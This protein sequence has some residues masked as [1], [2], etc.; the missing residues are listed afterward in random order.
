LQS[1]K[2]QDTISIDGSGS[3]NSDRISLSES[4]VFHAAHDEETDEF[5]DSGGVIL[6]SSTE[7]PKLSRLSMLKDKALSTNS[8]FHLFESNLAQVLNRLEMNL[9]KYV[10]ETNQF[11]SKNLEQFSSSNDSHLIDIRLMID[12]EKDCTLIETHHLF[13]NDK[14]LQAILNEFN[15]RIML[16]LFNHYIKANIY[17]NNECGRNR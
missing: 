4:C 9:A 16:N 1:A 12:C 10:L 8:I 2:F 11:D 3:T 5:N 6:R 17:L 14:H 15:M 7:Q 13:L